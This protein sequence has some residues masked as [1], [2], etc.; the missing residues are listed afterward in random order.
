MKTLTL[1]VCSTVLALTALAQQPPPPPA[2][3]SS[4][5]AT[6]SAS[7]AT[8]S[9]SLADKIHQKLDKK[10]KGHHGIVIDGDD[11]DLGKIKSEDIPEFVIPIVAITMLTIF[12]AP[13]LIVAFIMYFGFSKSRMQHRTIRMLAEKGQP[14]PAD[15]LA[16]PAPAIRQRSDMRRGIVLVMVG[17]GLM[18]CFGAW[19]DWEG[20]AWALGVIPFVIGLGYLLVWKLEGDKKNEI[21]PPPPKP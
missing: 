10:L 12:G 19:N 1:C 3:G 7:V 21:P 4:P 14:I 15:L 2:P 8:S 6:A 5:T 17:V 11:A 9:G 20:G 13:V 18:V 16:P